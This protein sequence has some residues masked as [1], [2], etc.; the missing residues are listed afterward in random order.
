[1]QFFRPPAPTCP[2]DP[3]SNNP[4]STYDQTHRRR[5]RH[6]QQRAV[7][8]VAPDPLDAHADRRRARGARGDRRGAGP[9]STPSS[10]RRRPSSRRSS[11]TPTPAATASATAP[12]ASPGEPADIYGNVKPVLPPDVVFLDSFYAQCV[13]SQLGLPDLIDVQ[14]ARTHWN[15]TLDAFLAPTDAAGNPIGPPIMLER[16]PRARSRCTYMQPPGRYVAEIGDVW[17]GTTYMATAAAVHIGRQTGDDALV[18]KALKMSEAVANLIFDDGGISTEGLRVRHAGVLVRGRRRPS[19]RYTGY[20]RA[21][22]G[23]AARRRARFA[24]GLA[25]VE[26]LRL[27]PVRSTCQSS[28]VT[29]CAMSA[30]DRPM[31]RS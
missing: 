17:P 26:L 9:R 7:P 12:A 8:A 21:A 15:N 3:P 20:A 6:L 22:L 25:E 1:M 16:G 10:P 29:T 28:T 11:G 18:A 24:A 4:P 19:S 23:L 13:A 30:L 27:A 31:W 5:S 14:N 2:A